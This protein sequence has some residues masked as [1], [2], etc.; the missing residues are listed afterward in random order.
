MHKH[1]EIR[2]THITVVHTWIHEAA[3]T[4]QGEGVQ[5]NWFTT[6]R[7]CT[8]EQYEKNQQC[9]LHIAKIKKQKLWY[10][11]VTKVHL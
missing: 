7:K 11:P 10:Q 3:I 6:Q 1:K 8:P 5:M 4:E 9:W 2:A